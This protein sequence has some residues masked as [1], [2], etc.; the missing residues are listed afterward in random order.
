MGTGLCE[1]C[2]KKYFSSAAIEAKVKFVL[3]PYLYTIVLTTDDVSLPCECL[4]CEKV[5]GFGYA[6][7]NENQPHHEGRGRPKI[8]ENTEKPG[9]SKASPPNACSIC[10]CLKGPDH[11]HDKCNEVTKIKNVVDLAVVDGSVTKLGAT[12]A[13]VAVKAT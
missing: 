2:R 11:D 6:K 4:I 10:Y 3:P 1:T 13:G 8:P 9:K 5:T 12:V 7:V